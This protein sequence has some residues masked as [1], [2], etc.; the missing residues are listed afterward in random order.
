MR[1]LF[2][3]LRISGRESFIAAVR[4]V[5]ALLGPRRIALETIHYEGQD[6]KTLSDPKNVSERGS[7]SV[8]RESN[9][10]WTDLV[11]SRNIVR[12]LT[13]AGEVPL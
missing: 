11:A 13:S 7:N 10:G 3:D 2:V 8:Q 6:H 5:S 1:A 4:S 9:R 12:L